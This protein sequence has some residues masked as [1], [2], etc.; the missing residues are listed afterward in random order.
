MYFQMK[1]QILDILLFW[2]LW[3]S[4]TQQSESMYALLAQTQ[5]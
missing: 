5:R 4:L 2:I 1:V 3:V